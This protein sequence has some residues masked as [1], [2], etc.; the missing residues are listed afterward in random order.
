MNLNATSSVTAFMINGVS[1]TVG[2][3]KNS[4]DLGRKEKT[5]EH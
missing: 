1:S 5:T 3:L 4:T 2:A